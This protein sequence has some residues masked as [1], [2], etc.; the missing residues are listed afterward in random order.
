MLPN[1]MM[2]EFPDSLL[3]ALVDISDTMPGEW[4]ANIAFVVRP[5]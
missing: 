2:T 1:G 4:M 3:K 5:L